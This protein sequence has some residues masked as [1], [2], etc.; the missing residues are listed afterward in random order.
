MSESFHVNLS[1]FG[2][3]VL[4]GEFFLFNSFLYCG[5]IQTPEVMI[6][7]T[8]DLYYVRK[9]SLKFQLFNPVVFE[10]K[11]LKYR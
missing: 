3:M 1:F 9:L 8:L 4:L 10:R 5:P 7:C 2:P 6:L 11:I